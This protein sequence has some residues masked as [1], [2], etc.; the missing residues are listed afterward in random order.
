ML[1]SIAVFPT[2]PQA[3]SYFA[4]QASQIFNQVRDQPPR[5]IAF[6]EILNVELPF[7]IA[8]RIKVL[9]EIGSDES[10][11][12]LGACGRQYWG[13]R[14]DR[15]PVFCQPCGQ[16]KRRQMPI[17][18]FGK[19]LRKSRI[20]PPAYQRSYDGQSSNADKRQE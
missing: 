19:A 18:D 16:A 2:E 20:G 4:I 11:I 5:L 8:N 13:G 17:A 3:G 6:L 14:D 15:S 9:F 1:T 7:K 12:F 10:N